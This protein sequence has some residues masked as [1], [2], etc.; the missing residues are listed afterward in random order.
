[1]RLKGIEPLS[2]TPKANSLP[3]ADNPVLIVDLSINICLKALNGIC[4]HNLTP[5]KGVL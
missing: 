2:I 5:T 4:T 1:M 3:L